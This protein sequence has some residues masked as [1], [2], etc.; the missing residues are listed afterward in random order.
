MQR[1]ETKKPIKQAACIPHI[2]FGGREVEQK[3]PSNGPQKG[4]QNTQNMKIHRQ[5]SE[6]EHKNDGDHTHPGSKPIQPIQ[7]VE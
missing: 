5:E 1:A 4:S 7:Q 6:E 2:D 3:K